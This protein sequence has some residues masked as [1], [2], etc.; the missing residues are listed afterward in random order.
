MTTLRLRWERREPPLSAAAVL[1]LGPAVPALAAAT[2]DRLRAGHRLSAATDGTALLVLGPADDL[3][4]ADGAHYLGLDG[5]LLVPT[6]ARPLPAAD[7]WRSALGAADGQLCA[8]VPGHGLVA[9]VPPPL[10]DPEALAAL[11]GGAA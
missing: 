11:L 6:T 2:R 9:D 4:W 3:P 8:L 5:R 7:L 1:A 10:T